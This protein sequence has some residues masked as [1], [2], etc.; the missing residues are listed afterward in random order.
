MLHR[1]DV[2]GRFDVVPRVLLRRSFVGARSD[3]C[4]RTGRDNRRHHGDAS[5]R[6]PELPPTHCLETMFA[7]RKTREMG[8]DEPARGPLV[9]APREEP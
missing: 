1:F 2:T 7:Q 6:A 8:L 9:S 3:G 4:E 5:Q